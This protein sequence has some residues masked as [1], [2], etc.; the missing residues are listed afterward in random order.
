M[1]DLLRDKE[2]GVKS[3]IEKVWSEWEER[4]TELGDSNR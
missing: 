3:E 1:K 4:C 2:K